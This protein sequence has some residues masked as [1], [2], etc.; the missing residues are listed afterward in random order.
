MPSPTKPRRR[1]PRL[2]LVED[3]PRRHTWFTSPLANLSDVHLVWAKTGIAAIT[4]LK[5][6]APDTYSGLMLDHD[7]HTSDPVL[8]LRPHAPRRRTGLMRQGA[9]Y[10]AHK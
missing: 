3:D 8:R 7:L 4:L 6:D 2:L 1:L 9:L 10:D 5:K